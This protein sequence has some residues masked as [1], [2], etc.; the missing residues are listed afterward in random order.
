MTSEE[1]A[2]STFCFMPAGDNGIRSLMYTSVA[3]GCLIVIVCDR[4]VVQDYLP[5]VEE[6]AQARLPSPPRL[7]S[8]SKVRNPVLAG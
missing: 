7:F 5:A 4:Y 6:G 2:S 3:V 8:L 1:M